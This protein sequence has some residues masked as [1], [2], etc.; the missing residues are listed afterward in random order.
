MNLLLKN[1][2]DLVKPYKESTSGPGILGYSIKTDL[3]K[4]INIIKDD[5]IDTE[6]IDPYFSRLSGCNF[7]ILKNKIK[8]PE[9]LRL[10]LD[11][12]EDYWLLRSIIR[13]LGQNPSRNEINKFFI[14]IQIFLK[15]IILEIEIGKI[16]KNFK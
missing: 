4:K 5:N 12:S 9:D 11:Y 3:L 6:M 8:N 15:L 1:K 16:N 14:K 2:L 13:I 10:T 7:E